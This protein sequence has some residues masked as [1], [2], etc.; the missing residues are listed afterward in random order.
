MPWEKQLLAIGKAVG[1]KLGQLQSSGEQ[2]ETVNC[3]TEP[4]SC[5][6]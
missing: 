3:E 5:M 2:M 1:D 6:G 4:G